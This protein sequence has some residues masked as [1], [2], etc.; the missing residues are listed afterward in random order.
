MTVGASEQ[1]GALDSG[2]SPN[3]ENVDTQCKSPV[4]K[5]TTAISESRKNRQTMM[6]VQENVYKIIEKVRRST[7]LQD[8]DFKRSSSFQIPPPPPPT[9]HPL[10]DAAEQLLKDIAQQRCARESMPF[11]AER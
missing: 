6:E 7:S 2:S 5:D 11:V 8:P 9:L 3:K 4:N 10:D 1:V